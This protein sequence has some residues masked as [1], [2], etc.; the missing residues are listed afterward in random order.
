MTHSS[1][2]LAK[3]SLHLLLSIT[4]GLFSR[5]SSPRRSK[6]SLVPRQGNDDV[7]VCL[8][9]KFAN[10]RFGLFEGLLRGPAGSEGSEN[11][12]QEV[13]ARV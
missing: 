7:G 6:I 13:M 10:P 3:Q 9:L 1:L 11:C 2:V 12:Q 5:Y 8:A 4:L